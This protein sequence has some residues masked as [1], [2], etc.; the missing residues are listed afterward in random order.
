MND[1]IYSSKYFD[2]II[3]VDDTTFSSVLTTPYIIMS[4]LS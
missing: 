1:I 3:Y 4:I 2:F